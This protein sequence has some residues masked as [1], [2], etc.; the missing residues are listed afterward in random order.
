MNKENRTL[1]TLNRFTI[2][3]AAVAHIDQAAETLRQI[4]KGN[5]SPNG[6]EA[7]LALTLLA[8]IYPQPEVI[9]RP[10]RGLEFDGGPD[11]A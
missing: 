1:R 7:R 5:L 4:I 3:E 10:W 11:A 8:H 2:D 6:E 9:S